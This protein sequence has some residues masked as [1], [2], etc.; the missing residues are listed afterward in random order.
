MVEYGHNAIQCKGIFIDSWGAGPYILT[1][2]G[3]VFYFEDSTQFGPL[4]LNAKGEPKNC[5]MF[6]EKCSFWSVWKRWVGEGRQTMLGKKKGFL[7][8]IVSNGRSAQ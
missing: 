7:Y 4:Q 3:K 5:G 8:C 2:G 1:A 6:E